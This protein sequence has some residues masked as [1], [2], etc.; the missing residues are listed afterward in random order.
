MSSSTNEVKTTDVAKIDSAKALIDSTTANIKK[1]LKGELP[2]D[3]VRS[4]VK[5]YYTDLDRLMKLLAPADS[6]KVER[7]RIEEGNKLNDWQA[8]HG[9]R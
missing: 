3:F 6:L 4:Q 2:N 8:A 9:E 7:Y 1:A 5:H